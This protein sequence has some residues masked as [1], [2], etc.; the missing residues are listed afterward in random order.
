[1]GLIDEVQLTNAE[2]TACTDVFRTLDLSG[3]GTLT[4]TEL[5][6]V[7][8]RP[9]HALHTVHGP[10][11][12]PVATTLLYL[13]RDICM[14]HRRHPLLIFVTIRAPYLLFILIIIAVL[15][16]LAML[17]LPLRNKCTIHQP[18]HSSLGLGMISKGCLSFILSLSHSLLGNASARVQDHGCG[19]IRAP[20]VVS[21]G[22]RVARTTPHG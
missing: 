7:K 16:T 1:M 15:S 3:S 5:K 11:V 19:L 2:K 9:M 4:H 12:V 21:A 6:K 22:I 18:M 8:V 17:V 20:V 10:A 13:N 14:Q